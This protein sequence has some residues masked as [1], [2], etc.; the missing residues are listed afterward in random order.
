MISREASFILGIGFVN[1][2]LGIIFA[3]IEFLFLGI[4]LTSFIAVNW[5]FYSVRERA[6]YSH[7]IEVERKIGEKNIDLAF[8]NQKILVT[9]T[10]RNNSGRDF[11]YVKAI[12]HLPESFEVLG[13]HSRI[14]KLYGKS[15][16]SYTYFAIP[17]RGGPYEFK[18][19]SLYVSDSRDLFFNQKFFEKKSKL[20]VYPSIEEI[21]L[22]K[23]RQ[24]RKSIR[25]ILGFHKSKQKG[26]GSDFA[27][28][29]DYQYGDAF[30]NIEWKSTARTSKLKTREFESEISIPSLIFLDISMSMDSGKIGYTKLDYAI[31]TA[32]SFS[33]FALENQDPVGIYTFL[34]EV[35]D[36]L[37][38]DLG[39][40][41]LYAIL[42]TLA[43]VKPSVTSADLTG[44]EYDDLYEAVYR[45]LILSHPSVFRDLK[46]ENAKIKVFEFIKE[47]YSLDQRE[48]KELIL[49]EEFGKRYLFRYCIDNGISFPYYA[50]SYRK[51]I[52]LY[53]AIKRAI[54]DAKG[55]TLFIIISDLEGIEENEKLKE[56]LKLS[57]TYHHNVIILSPFTPW[58]EHK[59]KEKIGLLLILLN[60]ILKLRPIRKPRKSIK[61]ITEELYLR[62]YMNR[63]KKF[64]REVEAMGIPV[65]SLSPE[66]SVAV[67]LS[68]LVKMKQRKVPIWRKI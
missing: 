15:E 59:E 30:K 63:R 36:Y 62:E 6:F 45:Y 23:L 19:V 47:Y 60:K 55:Q 33:K 41:H 48:A 61:E 35:H 53:N 1:C 68:Q 40:N 66:D 57:K 7:Y 8:T 4:A 38:P 52:G 11:E 56:A 34:H 5:L 12:D 16:C 20:F 44:V 31:K 50:I 18:G 22:E 27:G 3:K 67:L 65:L 21:S 39:R 42:K 24:S 46:P 13:S 2:S 54:L 37:K 10:I 49:S 17:K 32:A 51:D 28:I 43:M 9:I 29:R 58:F 25:R 14:F 26:I 64:T